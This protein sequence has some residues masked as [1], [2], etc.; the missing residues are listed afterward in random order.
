MLLKKLHNKKGFTLM[1]GMIVI[2]IIGICVA[3]WGFHGRDHIK[4]SMMN[5]AKMFIDKIVAQ[6]KIYRAN[7]GAFKPTPGTGAVG[8]MEDL[9]INTRSNTYFK[10][11]KIIVPAGT[12][13]TLIV[14][15]YPNTKKYPDMNGY[16]IRGVYNAVKDTV[17]YHEFFG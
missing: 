3:I 17:E 1:E 13:G 2:I 11:F 15:I 12:T 10:T 6:E 16:Y 9:Y 14:E 5:E 8:G 4:L 7:Q